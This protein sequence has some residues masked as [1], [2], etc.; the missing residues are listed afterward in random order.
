[1]LSRNVDIPAAAEA[2]NLG[3]LLRVLAGCPEDA[4]GR[5]LFQFRQSQP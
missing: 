3:Q 4:E 2:R 5:W 1:V